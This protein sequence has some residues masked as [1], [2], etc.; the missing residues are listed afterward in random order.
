MQTAF[1]ASRM[2]MDSDKTPGELKRNVM[3]PGGT[4][5]RAVTHL[6]EAG[7]RHIMA[8]AMDSCAARAREMADELGKH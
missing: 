2:A 6:E 1:G 8:E 4:T 5:E 7:L 3:S